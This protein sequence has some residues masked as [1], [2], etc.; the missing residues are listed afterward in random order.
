MTIDT[1][2]LPRD[3]NEGAIQGTYRTLNNGPRKTVSSAGTAV[4][5]TSTSTPCKSIII[6][7]LFSN[8]SKIAVG[9]SA[10]LAT[11]GSESGVILTAGASVTL[12]IIDLSL[13]YIDALVNGEG[14]T[15]QYYV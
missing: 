6:Q 8:T 13:V 4:K 12:P 7:A 2:P 10:T 15:S 1:T 14:V 3:Y 11:A 9:D 5:I